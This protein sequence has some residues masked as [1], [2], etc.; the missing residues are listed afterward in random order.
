PPLRKAGRSRVLSSLLRRALPRAVRESFSV[1]T[2]RHRA[3]DE[4]E[5]VPGRQRPAE[6]PG[7]DGG[8]G[9]GPRER[10]G[11][12]GARAWRRAVEERGGGA[13]AGGGLGGVVP[14]A[15]PRT[16]GGAARDRSPARRRAPAAPHPGPRQ[17]G[18]G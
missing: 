6:Q 11:G 14:P 3:A 4:L 17:G 7:E 12:R 9:R 15:L 5:P 8:A 13:P 18:R 2:H 10:G 16:G 1:V